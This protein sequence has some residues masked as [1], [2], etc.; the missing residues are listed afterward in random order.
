VATLPRPLKMSALRETLI[1]LFDARHAAPAAAPAPVLAF[2]AGMAARLPLRVLVAEDNVVNQ[3]VI[4][5][6]LARLGYRPDVVNNGLE[7]VE[8]VARQRYDVLLLDVQM[9]VMDGFEAT[10]RITRARPAADRPRIVGMTAL[11]MT[12]DRERC[13]EAGMEDYVSKPV[14]PEELQRALERS[15]PALAQ[16]PAAAAEAGAVIDPEVIAGL[17]E[18]QDEDE[19]DFVSE[20]IDVLLADGPEKLAAIGEA[21]TA[22]NGTA[23]NRTAHSLKSSCGNLGAKAMAS[24][25]AAI[26]HRGAEG[27]LAAVAT[28]LPEALAEFTRVRAALSALRQAPPGEAA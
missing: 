11:T 9:P 2:D 25:L 8:A 7:A 1:G 17:R 6:M 5:K 15:A 21:V 18:L 14:R 27:D 3:K 13:L 23:V 22:G 24:L 19:P 20:L 12:G 4:V 26:E 10:R 28:L 16:A